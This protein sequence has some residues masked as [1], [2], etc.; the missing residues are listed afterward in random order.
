V[1]TPGF[2]FDPE[3]IVG[4]YLT[5]G[6]VCTDRQPSAQ[7]V[8]YLDESCRI[9]D[10]DGRTR[11]LGITTDAN[12]DT[13]HASFSIQG[14]AGESFLD[15]AAVLEPFAA[16]LGAVLGERLGTEALPWLAAHL[17][18]ASATTTL[19]ELTLATYTDA[20]DDH[21]TLTVEIANRAFLEA[22]RPSA[23][24]GASP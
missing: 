13:A 24:P 6:Y 23:L 21:V 2:A 14:M 1:A 22:P 18:D 10:P 3:S 9:V 20:P 19:G 8:G 15:P 7:A 12:D 17:G 5:L 11:T 16:F 4:Y